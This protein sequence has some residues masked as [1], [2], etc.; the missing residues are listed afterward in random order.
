MKTTVSRRDF[1]K[2]SAA[3]GAVATTLSFPAAFGLQHAFAADDDAQTILNIAATAETFAVTH[4]YRAL[5]EMKFNDGEKAYMLAAMESELL[6]RNFLIANGAK[7]IV[8]E[9]YF[10]EGTFKDN[11]S[12][13][14]VTSVAE[15]VFVAAYLALVARVLQVVG[16]DVLP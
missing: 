15:T 9:F 16:F 11:K 13:G 1:L 12:L 8:E 2:V 6:H 4:Y 10:P 5:S 14:A 7:P 3:I